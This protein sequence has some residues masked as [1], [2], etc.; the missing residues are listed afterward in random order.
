MTE[1]QTFFCLFLSNF[2][3]W[4]LCFLA[5]GAFLLTTLK[6]VGQLEPSVIENA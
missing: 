4:V 5:R 3:I 1:I 6:N 2:F